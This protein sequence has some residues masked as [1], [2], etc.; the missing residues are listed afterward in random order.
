M[1]MAELGARSSQSRNWRGRY[2]ADQEGGRPEVAI[3]PTR[4][5]GLRGPDACLI[6]D[7]LSEILELRGESRPGRSRFVP[8]T[9][10]SSRRLSLRR[11]TTR[12]FKPR[13]LRR[14]SD[15]PPSPRRR[16]PDGSTDG[17]PDLRSELDVERVPPRFPPQ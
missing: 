8:A 3:D 5:E 15:M 2:G 7:F 14:P 1:K 11:F 13:F 17:T 10:K 16:R 4:L 12:F 6:A 9:L